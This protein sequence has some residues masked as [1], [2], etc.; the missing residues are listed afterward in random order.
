MPTVSIE[1]DASDEEI[2]RAIWAGLRAHNE[3]HAGTPSARPFAVFA[4]DD[5]GAAIGG[6]HG[7]LR[8][9]WL[10]VDN[11]W[12]PAAFRGQGLGSALS[13]LAGSLKCKLLALR[14]AEALQ[15]N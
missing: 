2:R 15:V 14:S 13:R 7:E 12:L 8:W 3:R 6:L 4:R 1:L 10:H 9:G 5:A 11:L